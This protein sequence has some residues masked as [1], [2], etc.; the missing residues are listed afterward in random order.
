MPLWQ[1]CLGTLGSMKVRC[2]PAGG[3][4]TTGTQLV[5]PKSSGNFTWSPT[6]NGSFYFKCN[7]GA[8]CTSGNMVLPVTVTGCQGT[9]G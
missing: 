4:E 3:C 1:P 9:K 2:C 8:H 7:V 5:P 6:S